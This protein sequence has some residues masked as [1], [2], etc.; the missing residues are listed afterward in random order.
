MLRTGFKQ[1]LCVICLIF[2]IRVIVCIKSSVK[3][4]NVEF[5]KGRI[6]NE[7]ATNT[8]QECFALFAQYNRVSDHGIM[9]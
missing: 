6:S 2:Y 7:T 1:L 5:L 3:F 4:V 8:F 9:S